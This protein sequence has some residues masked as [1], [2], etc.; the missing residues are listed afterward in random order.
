MRILL[1]EPQGYSEQARRILEALGHVQ[2]GPLRRQELLATVG[3][4]DVLVIRLAH[5]IDSEVI[6]RANRMKAI[7]TTTTGLDHIDLEA[8]RKRRIAVLSLR[9]ERE[10]LDTVTAT[11][12]HTWGL[13]LALIR[14]IPAAHA[15]AVAGQWERDQFR[16]RE[17]KGRTLGVVGYGR[18]GR[19]VARYGLAFGMQVL[20]YDRSDLNTEVGVTWVPLEHLLETADCVTLHLPLNETTRCMFGRAEFA[21][22]RH[23]VWFLNTSRG[24]LIDDEALLAALETGRLGGAALDVLNGEPDLAGATTRSLLD[25][26]SRHDNLIITPHIGGATTE[27]MESTEIFMAQKL[28]HWVSEQQGAK[29]AI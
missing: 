18:L 22:M 14:R 2:T 16:G 3:E 12:E 1:L 7:V 17:L 20:A 6:V 26:A 10:F 21:R 25:Y 29:S 24:G 4:Y 5:R 11:A 13:L 27:S 8:A 15:S 9:G 28:K 23:G 19:M